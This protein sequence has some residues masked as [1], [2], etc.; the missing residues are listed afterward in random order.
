M[1]ASTERKLA[2][3]VE[4]LVVDLAWTQ[5]SALSSLVSPRAE[6]ARAIIDPEALI[7]LSVMAQPHERR[8]LD[9]ATAWIEQ[10]IRF[11]SVQRARSLAA[12]LPES[13]SHVLGTVA[14]M[15]TAA[16]DHRWKRYVTPEGMTAIEAS[17]S[18]S[19]GPLRLDSAPA[20][21][22]RLRAGFGAGTKADVLATLL[23][24]Q[25]PATLRALSDALSYGLRPLR[26]TLD[27]MV[28]AGF[29][30]RIGSSPGTY[31]AS[32]EQWSAVLNG[33]RN[34]VP[35]TASYPP[36]WMP[37]SDVTILTAHLL[38]CAEQAEAASWSE[39]VSNSRLRDVVERHVTPS[40]AS[41]MHVLAPAP[42]EQWDQLAIENL[43]TN[44]DRVVRRE[45]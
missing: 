41:A 27:D 32:G 25:H 7:L 35:A 33:G 16:G 22:L 30:E 2:R 40:I 8:L 34:E 28:M 45:W 19:L 3:Q 12:R 15:A 29:V 17:R 9:V 37:W 43:L 21:M 5:W 1:S 44:I 23:G 26:T 4:R 42:A 31:R 14:A 11:V 18:K 10:G 13:R 24:L 36:R 38:A 39:Y 6:P 20:L